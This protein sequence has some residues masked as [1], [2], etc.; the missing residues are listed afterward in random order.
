MRHSTCCSGVGPASSSSSSSSSSSCSLGVGE[1]VCDTP[2]GD[3]LVSSR[4]LGD[5]R[6]P[7]RVMRGAWRA[8]GVWWRCAAGERWALVCCVGGGRWAVGG[9][10]YPYPTPTLETGQR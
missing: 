1:E 5:W 3:D 4:S 10:P 9:Y 8:R 2:D 6:E 7:W